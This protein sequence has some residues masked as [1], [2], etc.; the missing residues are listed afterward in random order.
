MPNKIIIRENE[1]NWHL[2]VIYSLF[3][4][5]SKE[6]FELFTVLNTSDH[7]WLNLIYVWTFSFIVNHLSNP[8]YRWIRIFLFALQCSIRQQAWTAAFTDTLAKNHRQYRSGELIVTMYK[9]F[10]RAFMLIKSDLNWKKFSCSI[11]ACDPKNTI[12]LRFWC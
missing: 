3:S 7:H 12:S 1:I 4:L 2:L 8:I 6:I 5:E 10:I 9:K 11:E